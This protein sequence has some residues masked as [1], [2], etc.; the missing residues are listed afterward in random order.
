M[1]IRGVIAP[2][3]FNSLD[4]V[5]VL[6]TRKGHLR[7]PLLF[8]YR[9]EKPLGHFHPTPAVLA[10]PDWHPFPIDPH[11]TAR[12]WLKPSRKSSISASFKALA[13]G[14]PS[15]YQAIVA[16]PLCV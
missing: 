9:G 1:D 4:I 15:R 3:G 8:C 12:G 5:S 16:T 7:V 11:A 14:P 2:V 13:A 6:L 10:L